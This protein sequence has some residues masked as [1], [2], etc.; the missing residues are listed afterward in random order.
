M[1]YL[2][3]V[4]YDDIEA[5]LAKGWRVLGGMYGHHASHAVLMVF[6]SDGEPPE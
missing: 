4:P 1:T 2:R 6:T 5:W 3:Y